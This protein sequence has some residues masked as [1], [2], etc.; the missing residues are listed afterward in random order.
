MTLSAHTLMKVCSKMKT[1]LIAG[2]IG[3]QRYVSFSCVNANCDLVMLTCV[4]SIILEVK[5]F[6]IYFHCYHECGFEFWKNFV[7]RSTINL[8][9]T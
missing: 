7:Q 6:A 8:F 5:Q 2:Y 1:I 3:N 9:E 4:Y